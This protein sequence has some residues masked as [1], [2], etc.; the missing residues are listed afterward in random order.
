[1]R[2]MTSIRLIVAPAGGGGR[3]PTE[4]SSLG[5]SCSMPL[6]LAEEVVMI[7]DVGV[8]VGATRFDHHFAQDPAVDELVQRVVDGRQRYRDGRGQRFAVQLLGGDVAIA[9][10]KEEPGQ[11]EA[12]A[13]R[14]QPRRA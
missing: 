7:L 3:L 13:R 9:V 14:P 10:F 2:I 8:E 12:L 1:M 5:M 6:E 4:T 11:G